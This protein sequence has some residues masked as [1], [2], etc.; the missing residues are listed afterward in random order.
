MAPGLRV[1]PHGVVPEN[2]VRVTL[3][4]PASQ[5]ALLGLHISEVQAM[6]GDKNSFP[7]GVENIGMKIFMREST[8][9]E[10]GQW[11]EGKGTTLAALAGPVL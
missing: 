7:K 8:E 6:E 1:I 10:Q 9:E 2:K 3:T 5:P 11:L 4:E